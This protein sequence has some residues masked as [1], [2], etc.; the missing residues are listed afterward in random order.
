V[1]VTATQSGV[2]ASFNPSLNHHI[3]LVTSP[4]LAPIP[5]HGQIFVI[6]DMSDQS[7]PDSSIFQNLFES[8][9]RDYENQ[10][11]KT[12]AQH[13]LSEQLEHCNSIESVSDFLQQQA[14]A[15]SGSRGSDG[16]IMKSLDCV[17]SVLY[18]LSAETVLGGAVG[19]VRQIH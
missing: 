6:C 16:R 15:F 2:G 19:L 5:F 13:P 14:R 1:L 17:V 9:L 3:S 7:A 18:T 10:T 4:H 12:W 11:G 8:A